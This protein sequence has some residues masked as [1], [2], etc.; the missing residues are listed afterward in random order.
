MRTCTA[1]G[2]ADKPWF[3]QEPCNC[4]APVHDSDPSPDKHAPICHAIGHEVVQYPVRLKVAD[5][6]WIEGQA[7]LQP[8]WERAGWKFLQNGLRYY[9]VK[10]LCRDC[11]G[12]ERDRMERRKDYEKSCKAVRGEDSQ[13]YAQMLAS[14]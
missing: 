14:Q 2:K 8:K 3:E 12:I 6:V 7:H 13:S 1:C 5:L 11:I 10:M 9:R 4:G